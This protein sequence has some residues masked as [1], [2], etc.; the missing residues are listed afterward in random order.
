MSTATVNA[1]PTKRFFVSM[2]TRDIEL[3]DAILDLLDNCID[4]ILRQSRGMPAKDKPYEGH[5]AKVT[6][7][8]REFNIVD[9]CGGIPREVARKSAFML[10][11][12]DETQD[13]DLNTVGMYGIG[14]KRAIFKMGQEC[15]VTSR[16][17]TGTYRVH[18]SPEWLTGDSWQ[19]ELAD[20]EGEGLAA[21]GTDIH[22]THLLPPIAEQFDTDRSN[23]I[24]D[25]GIAISELFALIIDKGFQIYV[26]EQK[27]PPVELMVLTPPQS[28]DAPKKG[29][30]RPYV[31]TGVIDS[32]NVMVCVGF[33]RRLASEKEIDKES[34]QPTSRDEAG[35]TVICNDRVVLHGDKSAV[36]GWGTATVPKY[37]NQ[38]IAIKGTVIFT[39]SY[40]LN[41][42]LNTT[43][44]GIDTSSAVYLFVLDYMRDGL[45][46][47][48]DFTNKWK[49][50]EEETTPAFQ[51]LER[52][53]P[54]DIPKRIQPSNWTI[55]RKVGGRGSAQYFAPELPM[56]EGRSSKRRVVFLRPESEIRVVGRYLFDDDEAEPS[57]VGDGCFSEVLKKAERR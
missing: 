11:R 56:P 37:H 14:M 32:V 42:P 7:N 51:A 31:F 24:N 27:I 6:A 41:L 10:G 45:K 1:S 30:I 13:A 23:F 39:S 29:E 38:F 22:I 57:A 49:T 34:E 2:L 50:R 18:I 53:K 16:P 4:G 25:L 8:P 28:T 40:S 20:V 19:L 36:T 48:T 26:N 21:T 5:W 17:E 52:A 55:V 33:Y 44:R 15:T 43:K 54:A 47:F 12:P 46:K 3:K 9:N 35:W